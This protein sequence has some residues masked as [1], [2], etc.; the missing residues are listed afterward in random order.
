LW[1]SNTNDRNRIANISYGH[2]SLIEENL[3]FN[4]F[5]D[6][7]TVQI[8]SSYIMKFTVLTS[9]NL[10]FLH[11]EIYSSY[12]SKNCKFHDG[13]TVN[14][15]HKYKLCI[16]SPSSS[17]SHVSSRGNLARIR[18]GD[19]PGNENELT[20]ILFGAKSSASEGVGL[21]LHDRTL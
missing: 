14:F 4:Q 5:H 12:W 6:V 11:H 7:R 3:S 21:I 19:W 10:Q 17:S 20:V 18:R 13:K 8:Y 1:S 15:K 16:S 2:Q 9:W